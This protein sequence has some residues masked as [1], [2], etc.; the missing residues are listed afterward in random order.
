M[1]EGQELF[2]RRRRQ[3]RIEPEYSVELLRPAHLSGLEIAVEAA[4]L[5]EPLGAIEIIPALPKLVL[6]EFHVGDVDVQRRGS[7]ILHA[8]QGDHHIPT[9]GER[10]LY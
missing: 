4:D 5:G 1:N 6:G 7:T 3:L 8:A 2:L 9:V 10:L